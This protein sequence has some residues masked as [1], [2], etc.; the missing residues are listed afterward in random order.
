MFTFLN[1]DS[2]ISINERVFK[3]AK[4][5][6]TVARYF[7]VGGG[8]LVIICVIGILFLI[9][10]VSLPLFLPPSEEIQA[11]FQLK[12]QGSDGFL[13]AAMD[14]YLETA[15][16]LDE[17]GLWHFYDLKK[18]TILLQKQSTP[19]SETALKIQSVE[20]YGQNLFSLVWQ[21]GSASLVQV[22][23]LPRFTEKGRHTI[24]D[25]LE[26]ASFPA[27]GN[28]I[29]LKTLT[30]ASLPE[31]DEQRHTLIQLFPQ[32]RI[33]IT[34]QII[35]KDFLGNQQTE[36]FTESLQETPSGNF[37]AFTMD[38][39]SLNL[40]AATDQGELWHWSLQEPGEVELL[41]N[42]T[43]FG[44]KRIITSLNLVF[45]DISLAV[46]DKK[47]HVTT[48]FLVPDAKNETRKTLQRV[49]T[50]P[51]HS[52]TVVQLIPSRVDKS[53]L[54]LDEEGIVHWDHTTTERQLLR[55]AEE[56]AIT[57]F[58]IA[59]RGNGLLTINAKNQVT[60][61][62][63]EN[64]HPEISWRTLF[65]KVL[66]EDYPAADYVWQSSSASD[67]FEPK[68]SL[69]PLIFGS[70][71]GTIYAM[72]LAIPLA[73]FG[74]I[75]TSQF[76]NESFR[77]FIK[78]G[79]EVMAAMP[80]VIIGFMI[81][82]WLAPIVEDYILA[83]FLALVFIPL[84]TLLF[85]GVWFTIRHRNWAKWIEARGYEFLLMIP[86]VM[87]ACLSTIPFQEVVEQLF[88]AGDFN[89]WL[90]NELGVRYEQRNSVI[91]AFG[92]GFMVIPIIF[93]I[94]EDSLTNVPAN[95]K[96]ASL[97][98]GASRWQTVW[99]IV[100]PS[101]SPGIFAACI[102]GFGRAIGETMVVLMATGNTPILDWSIFNGMR[103]LAANIA[104]ELPE[105]PVDGTLYRILFL[106]AVVLFLLTSVF[107]TIAEIIRQRLRKKYGQF[108]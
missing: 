107:N 4:A 12:Q 69:V 105:A 106:S 60:L 75:Y 74:A 70:F 38:G 14:E 77:R 68:F 3:R 41:Q 52:S 16:F 71:K 93:T 88:F 10:S 80:S 92:L 13:S 91:I 2:S 22:Q 49:H 53:L 104:V 11:Q 108:Q 102:I 100:I 81:A 78:P 63:V 46:G 101:A 20:F 98:L 73:L 17:R 85:V 64:P 34:Q 18:G 39:A 23:F 97:A 27:N 21:D 47:G 9:A 66:Y 25:L 89:Q 76:A 6:D 43:A 1:R 5:W 40:Y 26:V 28:D 95:L 15:S 72:I 58:N 65:G 7:I 62:K 96:Y 54:S 82:L 37:T 44:D 31:D 19:P 99:R 59:P 79:V 83:F 57:I 42:F 50:L 24:H 30:R 87:V 8:I 67:D 55:F 86:V 84:A 29:P 103:T 94:S 35:E 36:S 48:W 45:G 51:S 56:H 90:F 61:W 33:E 32:N